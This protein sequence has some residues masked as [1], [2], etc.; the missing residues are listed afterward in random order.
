MSASR[1]S[2]I[3]AT[4]P[5]AQ[6]IF[7]GV[8]RLARQRFSGERGGEHSDRDRT[9]SLPDRILAALQI[10]LRGGRLPPAEG[11]GRHYVKLPIKAEGRLQRR[12]LS[13]DQ[14]EPSTRFGAPVAVSVPM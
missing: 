4:S 2:G 9:L 6:H 13:V 1:R 14:D 11:D 10:N 12:A 5:G 7:L 3:P 8:V